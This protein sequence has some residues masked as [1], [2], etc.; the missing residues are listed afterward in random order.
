MTNFIA[1]AVF[2]LR[3]GDGGLLMTVTNSKLK[4]GN[5]NSN[6]KL[7]FLWGIKSWSL[8]L[9]GRRIGGYKWGLVQLCL[10]QQ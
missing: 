6:R 4:N 3:I 2:C 10:A 8:D 1:R 9:T 5:Y 7:H